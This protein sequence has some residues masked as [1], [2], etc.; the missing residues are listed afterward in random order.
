M[1]PFV[2][3]SPARDNEYFSDGVS[4]ELLN[5]LAKMDRLR[6]TGRTSSFAFKGKN[7]DLRTIGEKLGVDHI[8]EGSVRKQG[9]WIRIN[10]QL[11]D[12][13]DGSHLWSEAYDRRLGDVFAIQ[14]DI[15]RNVTAAVMRTVLV[16][17]D[18]TG[19][20]DAPVHAPPTSNLEAYT[21]YLRGKH[22]LRARIRKDM[23]QAL[24]QFERA[25]TQDQYFAEAY[26][27]IADSL[28]LLAAYGFRNVDKIAAPAEEAIARALELNPRLAEAYA[29]K[30]RLNSRFN[31]PRADQ[32]ELIHQALQLNPNDA[33]AL[34]SLSAAMWVAGKPVEEIVAVNERA[35]LIDPLSPPVV[36]VLAQ[37]LYRAGQKDRGRALRD[38]L[39]T[40]APHFAHR[41]ASRFAGMEGRID[42]V[43]R[44]NARTIEE[45]PENHEAYIDLGRA[46]ADLG[47]IGAAQRTFEKTVKLAPESVTP[48]VQLIRLHLQ[49]GDPQAAQILVRYSHVAI[50]M[51]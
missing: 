43:A 15:A 24:V 25:V 4:E 10:V 13:R 27:G 42:E 16:Q 40:F 2:D 1:L 3:L 38:E 5:R 14:E 20:I 49:S 48:V 47:D 19:G 35:Y 23:E 6:V 28:L 50:P 21:S 36:M 29:A 8:L 46:Y 7:E 12:A 17:A 44:W 26:V 32:D 41:V 22:L 51:I 34:H 37:E 11:V 45:D 18:S 9:E 30:H 33:Y 31:A 39:A